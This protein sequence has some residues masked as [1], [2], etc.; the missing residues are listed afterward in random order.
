MCLAVALLA[1]S[2][3]P[4]LAASASPDGTQVPPAT[5]VVD[6]SLATWTIGSNKAILRNGTQAGGGLGS[7]ILWRGSVIY[8][9][10]IDARWYYWTGS[11]W[12]TAALPPS[13][14]GTQ[15]PPALTIIDSSPATWAIGSGGAI[16]RNGA[17]A[18]GGY[19]SIIS[20]ASGAI[21]VYGTD[22]RW[23]KWSGSGW[24]A[25]AASQPSPSGTEVP[26]AS[27]IIDN[28]LAAWT[29]GSGGAILRNGV[30]AAGGYGS[31]I[32]WTNNVL[33]VYGTDS[34]WYTWTGAGWSR[35]ATQQP[36]PDLTEVPPA[37]SIVDNSLATWS[38]ASDLRILRNGTQANGGYGSDLY[39]Y[40]GAI[41]ALGTDS[42]W[43]VWTGSAWSF[44]GLTKPG[45]ST[46][47][48]DYYVSPGQSIQSVINGAA[49]G[50]VIVLNAG[51]Y[52]LQS[53]TPK[54]G[55]TIVGASG[56]VLSGARLLTSFG[57]S[58]AAWVAT[59][60]TQQG[61]GVGQCQAWAPMC[62]YPEDLFIDDRR[63]LH[64]ANFSDGAPGRWY[65]DYN[66][67][68]I[69]M[70]DDPTNHRVEASVNSYAIGGTA[71][72]VSIKN[73]IVEKYANPAQN[74]AINSGQGWILDGNQVRWNHGIGIGIG[75]S[76]Q[77]LRNTVVY[78]GQMGI[79]GSG[80][81]AV[82]DSNE[83]A[84]NNAA[85]YNAYWEGGGSKFTHSSNLIIRNNFVHHNDGPGIH[86]D[87]DD[88][89][90]L[91][92]NNRVEDNNLSG[93][94][95]EAGYQMTIRYNSISRNGAAQPTPYWV[96]G[97]G[98]LVSSSPNVEVYGNTLVDNFQGI[99]GLQQ[100]NRSSSTYGPLLLSNL[101]VHDN[102]VRQTGF[103]LSGAGRTGVED[104]TG[105][106]AFT[107]NNRF[108]NNTY[109][110][111]SMAQYF[112][113]MHTNID[114]SAWRGY[115]EDVTGTFVR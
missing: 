31:I 99:T 51:V 3:R 33:S 103:N 102:T 84:Y 20:W 28:S 11:S 100:E 67:D 76:S 72:N 75:P 35:S 66:A 112:F 110:L 40:S 111:G 105:T 94:F 108:V 74:A 71:S 70:W 49:E 115:G 53:I 97:A 83:I 88:I 62:T 54:N 79:G 56:A 44:Y 25:S 1:A 101:Y 32:D 77:V 109:Y 21:S 93:I 50:K 86:T 15:A 30:Q 6:S 13:S 46:V 19:G 91:V 64:V 18:A 5:S 57:R 27:S 104:A 114:E 63:L 23:Y 7:V 39:W 87:L 29:I 8:V 95:H 48:G 73:L 26:P 89:Y 82:V 78:N 58:G 55:Q 106:G 9:Y 36:S 24:T 37:S 52:R 65:F 80:S 90:G 41:Y 16:L 14:S 4:G 47:A 60:Q 92:E 38:I 68:A 69:Y 43:Y 96:D 12:N 107:S 85:G 22:G 10:G 2:P 61:S 17:Q 113:W 42:R 34:R 98:I 45:T 59:G 81:N